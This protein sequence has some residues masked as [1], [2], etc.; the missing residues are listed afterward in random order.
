MKK[1]LV[2]GAAGVLGKAVVSLLEREQGVQLRLTDM[3]PLETS[4]EFVQADLASWGESRGLCEGVDE[5]LHI[6]AIH[7]W[8][9]YTPQ[10]YVDCNIKGTCNL[11]QAAADAG[12]K[13]AIYTSSIAAMGYRYER[14]EELPFDESR[15]CRP[16]EDIY[17]VSKHVG[18]QLC[19]M[20]RHRH[21]MPY[22]AL[23]P[24]TFVPR[25]EADPAWGLSLLTQWLHASDV[26]MAHVLALR[27]D[28]RNEAII[29]TAKVPFT[30]ADAP[31]LLADARPVIL[32]YFPKAKLLEERGV[33]LPKK[34]DRWYN[35]AKAERLLGYRPRWSFGEWLERWEDRRQDD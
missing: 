21:G 13:R 18:E 34:I 19:E 23:R 3:V 7:P 24:G 14:P 17:C 9:K 11:L 16:C 32:R 8:R 1:I 4:H 22:I 26:A 30:R 28:L 20:M 10:Q 5:V 15:P 25:D 12:V 33:E 6:A 29:I 2:T 31:A 35:I 27:S